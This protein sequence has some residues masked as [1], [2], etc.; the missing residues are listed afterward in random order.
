M[1]TQPLL[2]DTFLRAQW[3]AE[4]DTFQ[5]SPASAELF[6]R[7]RAWAGRDQLN[8]RASEE[9]TMVEGG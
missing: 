2:D 7:L 5:A 1:P 6:A 3:A 8:E 4:F 9:I